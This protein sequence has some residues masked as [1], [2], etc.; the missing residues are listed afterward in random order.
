MAIKNNLRFLCGQ[1]HLVTVHFIVVP[2]NV[3]PIIGAMTGMKDGEEHAQSL[4]QIWPD[5]SF[6]R[7]DIDH[8]D[9]QRGFRRMTVGPLVRRMFPSDGM[10]LMNWKGKVRIVTGE[11]GQADPFFMGFAR[12]LREAACWVATGSPAPF[13]PWAERP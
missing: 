11:S 2:E 9:A 3:P 6:Q 4:T 12:T 7:D 8:P 5:E 1:F 13:L 10:S